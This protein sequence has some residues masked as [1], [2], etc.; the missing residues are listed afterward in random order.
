MTPDDAAEIY[1]SV[2]ADP[3]SVGFVAFSVRVADVGRL[4]SDLAAT[5]IP[6]QRIGSRLIVP[7]SAAFGVAIAFEPE[8]RA[9]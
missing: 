4:A 8:R 9:V 3:D 6:F 7:S 1:A 2:E 5:A